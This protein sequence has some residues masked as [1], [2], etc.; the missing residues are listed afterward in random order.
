MVRLKETLIEDGEIITEITKRSFNDSS[1]RFGNGEDS[2]PPGYDSVE[3]NTSIIKNKDLPSYKIL[4]DERIVGWIFISN[5]GNGHYELE[6]ICV[7]PSFQGKCIGTRA[8]K[9]LEETITEAAMWT[10]RAANYAKRNHHFYEK[11]GF[12]KVG[13]TEDGFFYLYEKMMIG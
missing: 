9:L 4:F 11:L 8:I 13:E 10:L 3:V 1:R 2:G 6:N 12:I 7:D 5:Q